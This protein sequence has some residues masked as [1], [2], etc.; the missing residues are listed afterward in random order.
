VCAATDTQRGDN[1]FDCLMHAVVMLLFQELTQRAE[2]P[3]NTING[4]PVLDRLKISSH[5]DPLSQ[6]NMEV[7]PELLRKTFEH[8]ILKADQPDGEST[9]SCHH[10]VPVGTRGRFDLVSKAANRA[11]PELAGVYV[12]ERAGDQHVSSSVPLGLGNVSRLQRGIAEERQMGLIG[13]GHG[14]SCL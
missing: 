2:L 1:A 3:V 7:G 12:T 11:A 5:R 10:L 8:R 14:V 13:S 9:R 6:V 4:D